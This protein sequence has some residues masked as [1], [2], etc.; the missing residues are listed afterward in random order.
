MIR[1][2]P[3]LLCHGTITADADAPFAGVLAHVR[4]EQHRTAANGFTWTCPDCR[5]VT[6]PVQ[7]DRCHGCARTRE[8]V[9][10]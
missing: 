6:I 8:L 3:C 5:M 1:T 2:E 9:A 7:R 4:G 10:A